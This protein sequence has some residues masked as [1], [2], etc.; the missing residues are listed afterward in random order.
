MTNHETAGGRLEIWGGVGG[1]GGRGCAPP[2]TLVVNIFW[3]PTVDRG[4]HGSM[5]R[6][7]SANS[8][9]VAA[10]KNVNVALL[11]VC[12]LLNNSA[13]VNFSV[14]SVFCSVWYVQLSNGI[15]QYKTWPMIRLLET[16]T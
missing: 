8:L 15:V 12:V 10:L 2:R 4:L 16:S 6:C 3:V 14:F 1:L 13:F 7:S 5:Q 9:S 11:V